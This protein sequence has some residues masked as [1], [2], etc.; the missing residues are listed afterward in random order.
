MRQVS[1]FPFILGNIMKL[2]V[3]A[4]GAHPDDIELTC[5]GTI[6]KLVRQGRSVGIV[7]LTEGELGTRGSRQLRQE[8]AAS[9]SKVLGVNVRE[10]LRIPDGNI[11]INREN[12]LKVIRAIRAYRPEILLFPYW[13]DRHPDHEHAHTLCREAMFYAGLAKIETVAEGTPQPPHRPGRWFHFMQWE[14]FTPSFVIDVSDVWPDRMKSILSYR[15]QFYDS[16]SKEPETV[17]SSP[18]FIDFLETRGKYYG[19]MIGAAYGE[20]FLAGKTLAF[21]SP[22]APFGLESGGS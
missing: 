5:S 21:R 4:V 18:D 1:I 6:L 2:D 11:L 12:L 3:L 14:E 16:N 9:A 20:P 17:L 15:S 19:D 13:K 22:D 10:N 7:D 8:E